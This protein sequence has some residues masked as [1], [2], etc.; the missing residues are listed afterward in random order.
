M[1]VNSG[2]GALEMCSICIGSGEGVEVIV[3]NYTFTSTANAFVTHGAT[4]VSQS[5]DPPPPSALRPRRHPA[6]AS[7]F[8]PVATATA[9]PTEHIQ[10]MTGAFGSEG[11]EI[12]ASRR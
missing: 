11:L 7:P 1:L 6:A 3:P 10:V 2:T 9:A 5:L 8:D 12:C 4:C